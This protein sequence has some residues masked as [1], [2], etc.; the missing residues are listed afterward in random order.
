MGSLANSSSLQT[1]IKMKS[2]AFAALCLF[3]AVAADAEAKPEAEADAYYGRYGYGLAHH[4]YGYGLGHHGYYG[5]YAHPYGAYGHYYGKRSAEAEAE[6]T[7]AAEP[8]ADAYY[9]RYGYGLAHHGYGYGL[10]HHGAYYGAYA[11]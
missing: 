9:G 7:A 1:T 3:A 2:V 8:A 11:H 4:G 6:P 5:A 10:A